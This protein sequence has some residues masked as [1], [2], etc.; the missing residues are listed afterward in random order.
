MYNVITMK[1]Q[2]YFEPV[3]WQNQ[4]SIIL[5]LSFYQ[6]NLYILK[7]SLYCVTCKDASRGKKTCCPGSLGKICTAALQALGGVKEMT[8]NNF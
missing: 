2:L 7:R 1:K 4:E 8:I 6:K 5:I 3:E